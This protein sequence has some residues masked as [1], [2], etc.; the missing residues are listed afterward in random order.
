MRLRG[1]VRR[2]ERKHGAAI[3]GAERRLRREE[4]VRASKSV[5]GARK[6]L[7]QLE[8][9]YGTRLPSYSGVNTS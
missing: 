1:N 7:E 5:T 4:N 8:E 3:R 6:R 2:V 9:P